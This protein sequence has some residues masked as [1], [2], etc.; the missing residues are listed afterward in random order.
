MEQRDEERTVRFHVAIRHRSMMEAEGEIGMADTT[1]VL[2]VGAGPTG[3]VAASELARRGVSC[4]LIDTA[5]APSAQ[6]KALGI[7]ARTLEMFA[8]MG[9]ADRFVAEGWKAHGVRIH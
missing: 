2:V 3:L 5:P 9:I 1:E 4:R 7:Q 6:S 8:L